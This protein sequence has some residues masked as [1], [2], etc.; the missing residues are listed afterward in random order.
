[1]DFR[2]STSKSWRSIYV[3]LL[4]QSLTSVQPHPTVPI[5]NLT[6]L[7]FAPVLPITTIL[8]HMTVPLRALPFA[9]PTHHSALSAR[10]PVTKPQTVKNTIQV[11]LWLSNGQL[12]AKSDKRPICFSF[13]ISR[14]ENPSIVRSHATQDIHRCSLCLGPHGAFACP[15]RR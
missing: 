1:M 11:Q 13:N 6:L 8:N 4:P 15:Q 3:Q 9:T 10:A 5:I 14:S 2:K 7:L 12:R